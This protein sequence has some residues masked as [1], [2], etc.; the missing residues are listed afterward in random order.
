MPLTESSRIGL[1]SDNVAEYK[2]KVNVGSGKYDYITLTNYV[3]EK[4]PWHTNKK[5]SD[6]SFR[7]SFDEK[8]YSD[9]AICYAQQGYITY[10]LKRRNTN[11]LPTLLC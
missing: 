9:M 11:I 3:Q 2:I 6:Y 7:A 1:V 5:E 8:F 10:V 4:S